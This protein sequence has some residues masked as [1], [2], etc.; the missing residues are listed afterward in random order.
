MKLIEQIKIK[1]FRS[2]GEEI[3][4][5]D[6]EDLNVFSGANDSGK[7]NILRALNLFFSKDIPA[8]I[9]FYRNLNFDEDFSKQRTE[10][11]KSQRKGKTFIE[12]GIKFKPGKEHINSGLL[13]VEFWIFKQFYK[14]YSVV[15]L[16]KKG[17]KRIEPKKMQKRSMTN[18]LKKIHFQY[19]PA[20][21][22]EIFSNYLI[23]EY[24][25]SLGAHISALSNLDK[26]KEPK[27]LEQWIKILEVKDLTELLDKKIKADSS[28]L[29]KEFVDKTSEIREANF[30]IPEFAI[31]FSKT[32]R[33]QTENN[34]SL[35][36]RGDGIQ[37]KFIPPLLNEISKN[38][39]LVIWGFEEPENSLEDRN[40]RE[41]AT[42]FMKYSK[43]KQIF[44]TTHSR[45]FLALKSSSKEIK[46]SIY[47]VFKSINST[48]QIQKYIEGKGFDRAEVQKSF[49]DNKKEE[50][51]DEKEKTILINIYEDL[52]IIDESR[53][54]DNLKKTLE[55]REGLIEKNDRLSEEDKQKIRHELNTDIENCL[56]KL[57]REKEKIK[58]YE[59]PIL[60]VEGELEEKLFT[61]IFENNDGY[62]IKSAGSSDNLAKKIIGL[63]FDSSKKI[64]GIFDKDG[65]GK[66]AVEKIRKNRSANSLVKNIYINPNASLKVILAKVS[67][68]EFSIDD[69]FP[70]FVWEYLRDNDFL[71]DDIKFNTTTIPPDKSREDF[72]SSLFNSEE[73]A[74]LKCTKKVK[75]NRKRDFQKYLLKLPHEN[76]GIVV[77]SLQPIVSEIESFFEIPSLIS[78]S[79]KIPTP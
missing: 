33:I 37:S 14:D 70:N 49:W 22:D 75:A 19:V 18:F 13:G 56:N 64:L 23:G 55:E 62:L 30:E 4:I 15:Y 11:L 9:D 68:M 76:W 27:T 29:F 26:A 32:L 10:E 43:D 51:R 20:I 48:S 16:Q 78:I 35:K 50:E 53:I 65:A 39:K 47:R 61:K 44:I 54:I 63:S 31:D 46:N 40:A 45:E 5:I 1:H 52:G 25:K 72:L 66:S 36:N 67:K 58:E 8:K 77:D 17:E 3:N 24:Q 74:I 79:D 34:I 59:K 28:Q 60:Y 57:E 12:I 21:K 38:E 2:F 69:L 42:V 7:S 41:L 6:T 73:F 71:E